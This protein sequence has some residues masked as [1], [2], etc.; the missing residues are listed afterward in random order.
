MVDMNNIV[1]QRDIVFMVLDSLRYDVAEQE[2]QSGNL[3]NLSSVFPKGWEKRHSPASFTYPAHQAFF[4]GFLPTPTDPNGSRQRLFATAFGGSETTGPETFVFEED[5]IVHGLQ[6][7]GYHTV[8]LGGVGFFNQRTALSQVLPKFF[9]ESHWSPKTG[10]T[11]KN[12]AQLQ[13]E[14]SLKILTEAT[15]KTFLFVNISCIHQPNCYYLDHEED[16]LETHAAALRE[17]AHQAAP[18]F[19]KLR[20]KE[21]FLIICSDHGTL[22]G[23]D[24]FTGHRV[25]HSNVYTVPY[26]HSL[27]FAS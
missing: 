12:S 23:E 3:P 2:F 25:G 18:L 6:N 19:K 8:C 20:E 27:L 10:V 13:I 14:H 16:S 17:F 4:A 21:A 11:G 5:N 26:A 24:G 15:S 22:Y 7:Q 1:G 9:Q